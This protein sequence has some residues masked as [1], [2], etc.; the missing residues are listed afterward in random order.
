MWTITDGKGDR[1]YIHC[2]KPT[3]DIGVGVMHPEDLAGMNGVGMY[4]YSHLQDLAVAI[5]KFER[6][7]C[8]VGDII[9][10][11]QD[12]IDLLNCPFCGEMAEIT[13]ESFHDESVDCYRAKCLNSH[14]LDEWGDTKAEAKDSWNKRI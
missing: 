5:L 3:N 7:T 2:D 6:N 11:L 12:D 14:A 9:N 13:T 10:I 8:R 4:G 1:H